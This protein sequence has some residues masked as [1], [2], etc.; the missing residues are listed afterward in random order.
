MIEALL[1]PTPSLIALV[2]T[3]GMLMNMIGDLQGAC[4]AVARI[5]AGSPVGARHPRGPHQGEEA[6]AQATIIPDANQMRSEWSMASSISVVYIHRACPPVVGRVAIRA[7]RSVRC[8]SLRRVRGRSPA[9]PPGAAGCLPEPS[10]LQAAGPPGEATPVRRPGGTTMRPPGRG[11]LNQARDG[12][13]ACNQDP[14]PTPWYVDR[15][16]ICKNVMK[17]L[18]GALRGEATFP[19]SALSAGRRSRP[20][21]LV[22]RLASSMVVALLLGSWLD[23]RGNIH[24]EARK[25][26]DDSCMSWSS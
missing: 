7:V 26:C 12:C 22:V 8:F 20:K 4:H 19:G 9:R 15:E 11:N 13:G 6:V 18:P 24:A 3:H 16:L 23:L 1:P 5:E 14:G 10:R 25:G 2:V 21:G 17:Y